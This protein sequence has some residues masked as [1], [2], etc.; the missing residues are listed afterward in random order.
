M[1]K[2]AKFVIALLIAITSVTVVSALANTIYFPVIERQETPTPT[3][4][5]TPTK[6]ATPTKTVTPTKTPQPDVYIS[7]INP[8]S[9]EKNDYVEIKNA[10]S[11]TNDLT[12]W[13]IKADSGERYDFPSGFD[14][15]GG[16]EVKVR[17]G[18]GSDT[19]SNLYWGLSDSLWTDKD[20]CAY[21]RDDDGDLIDKKC[22][23]DFD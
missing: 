1:S 23:D 14:L 12:D 16:D 5:G 10:E 4:T 2:E 19:S 20:N 8:S 21:L 6:T 18:I 9:D 3:I 13:W 11:S 17:S 15:G 7:D 22:V